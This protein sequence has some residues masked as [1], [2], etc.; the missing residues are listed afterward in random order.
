MNIF[1]NILFLII[2]IHNKF[3]L[4]VFMNNLKDNQIYEIYILNIFNF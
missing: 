1:S 4:N 3:D 2:I